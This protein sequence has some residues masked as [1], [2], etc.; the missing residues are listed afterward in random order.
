MPVFNPHN[1]Q[2]VAIDFGLSQPHTA[3][4][5]DPGL[6]KTAAS[7]DVIDELRW[8]GCK[9]VLVIAPLRVCQLTW[10]EQIAHWDNYNHI[11]YTLLHGAKGKA[12]I[13]G[14]QKD[15]YLINPEGL[16]W[17]YRWCV[18]WLRAGHVLP[19]DTLWI[20]ESDKFKSH[21]AKTRF[22]LLKDMLPLFKKRHIMTGTPGSQDEISKGCHPLW[23]QIY[24]L[25]QGAS[26]GGNYAEFERKYYHQKPYEK[27]KLHINPGAA[28]EIHA[29]I[30]HLVLDM[31]AAE[32][33]DLPELIE[34]DIPVQLDSKTM[35]TYRQMERKALITLDDKTVS[36]AHAGHVRMQLQQMANGR[37][38]ED[39]PRDN[40]GKPIKSSTPR[41]VITLHRAKLDALSDLID[42]L[43]GKPMLVAYQFRH[44]LEALRELLGRDVPHIGSGVSDADAQ[45]ACAAFNAGKL[46]ILLGHPSSMGH[47]LNLQESANDVCWYSQT[48]GSLSD[49]IQFNARVYRQGAHTSAFTA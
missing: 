22:K 24:L 27:Y 38:Y 40:E 45:K 2:G 17:L 46:P 6:G 4:F 10:P 39:W 15:I 5:L 29:K 32:H 21:K 9:G 31:S 35:A 47:G 20:D 16:P 42:E 43:Q 23:S 33:L 1:Y 7:L 30:A 36:A 19:F 26:L 3:W 25:D 37:V 49:Y 13:E 14:P 28:D 11:T 12:T 8:S 48:R 44:D 34:N 18:K 41:N